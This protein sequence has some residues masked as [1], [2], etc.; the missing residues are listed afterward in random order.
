MKAAVLG[1]GLMGSVIAWDLARAENVDGVVVADIDSDKL[2]KVKRSG[3]KKLSTEIVDARDSAKLSRF[4]KGF[5]VVVS[6][7]PHGSLHAADVVAV[8]TG[9]KMVNIAFEDEQMELDSEAGKNE[10]L[11]IPGCGVA[12]GLGGV[13]L[14]QG[15]RE[16]GGATEG[17]IMVG[18]L[19]QKPRPP[20]GYRLV[21]SVVGL[22]K[23]YTDEARIIRNGKLVKVK[24]FEEV[25]KVEF[26][27]PIGSCEAFYT[28]GL[29]TLLYSMKGLKELDEMTLRWPGHAEKIKFLV[30]AGFLSKQSVKVAGRE[31]APIDLAA[32]VL[33]KEFSGG[34]PEDMTVMRVEVRGPVGGITFEVVDYYDPKNRV[35]SMGK[36]TGYTGSVVAQMVGSGEVKGKGVVPPEVAL[37]ADAVGKLIAELAK[38][39]V[40]IS[41]RQGP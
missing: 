35:T 11:L 1:S 14:A 17:H 6:A 12:P 38:R 32:A 15:A 16:L 41:E 8:K 30:D 29:A 34:D 2:E 9:T 20:F 26:P 19:P 13:L 27:A 21:F 31:I 39:G 10:S 25:K 7:L 33:S 4:I 3:G 36:T 28:D 23:E 37:G 22:L 40:E 18:G 5:D 24:P